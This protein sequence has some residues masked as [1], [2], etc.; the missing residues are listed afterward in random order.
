MENTHVSDA[1]LAAEG[2]RDAARVVATLDT[3]GKNAC[4]QGLADALLG[5]EGKIL[6]ANARDLQR[7]EADGLSGPKLM[8]LAITPE[9]LRRM[10]EGLRQVASLPDPVAKV[11]SERTLENGL[12]V[13][14]VRCPLGVIMMIYESRPNVT[15]D[16][17]ALCFKSGN[18]CILKGGREAL[19]S[20]HALAR[21]IHSTLSERGVPEDALVLVG[22][23]GREAVAELLTLD[24]CIDLVIPR[25][26]ETLIRFVAENS[27]IPTVQHYHGVCHLYVDREADLKQALEI[28]VTGKTS[29]PATCN[30][31]E[32]IIVHADIAGVFVPGLV[33]RYR[34]AGVAVRG[35]RAVMGLTPDVVAASP[36]DWGREFLDLIVAVK[37]VSDLDAAV[38][39]IQRFGSNHTDA[40]VTEN[41]ATAQEFTQ[42]IQSSCTLVNASTRFNDGFQLGMGAEIGISTSRV[43]AYGPMGLEELTSQRFVV[44]GDGHVR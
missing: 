29:A 24:D 22:A 4:L 27:S 39:H 26:G 12:F 7:A 41:P 38:D 31:T 36:D 9:G 2:A 1:R 18:A 30:S 28:A 6:A 42:R 10:A 32:A 8:R 20:N 34:E 17:F 25:G 23:G 16:A 21:V 5:A 13:K 44:E 19:E 15:I 35:D 37:V 33:A 40:I 43:H 14:R 3:D 11:T